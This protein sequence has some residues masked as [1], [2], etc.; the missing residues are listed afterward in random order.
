MG[1]GGPEGFLR[2]TRV[3][4]L[5]PVSTGLC[6][7]VSFVGS[8]TLSSP[9]SL[10]LQGFVTRTPQTGPDSLFP[11]RVLPLSQTFCPPSHFPRPL[12]LTDTTSLIFWVEE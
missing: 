12:T 1:K 11:G 7:C 9:P 10:P 3:P 6:L 5:F 8:C 2:V 4:S